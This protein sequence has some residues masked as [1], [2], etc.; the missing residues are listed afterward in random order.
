MAAQGAWIV[1]AVVIARQL[2]HE[3]LA[4]FTILRNTMEMVVLV[5]GVGM[6]LTCI[7][8]I[9]EL[10][11]SDPDGAGRI[12][13]L[14]I[15][16]STLLGAGV[17][18]G[19]VAAASALA[20][21]MH[22]P[23][24]VDLMR[25]TAL[26]IW[27][28][29]Q[30]R[31]LIA[32]QTGIENFRACAWINGLHAGAMLV[33]V[34]VGIIA[35]GITGCLIGLIAATAFA[36]FVGIGMTNRHLRAL[37]I[38]PS[39]RQGWQEW[40]VLRDFSVPSIINDFIS[41]AALWAAMAIVAGAAASYATLGIFGAAW[42]WRMLVTFAP[43]LLNNVLLPMLAA[44]TTPIESARLQTIN[45][46]LQW[47]AVIGIALPMLVAPGLIG[48][49]YG[50]RL[51]SEE[52]N[53]T[54]IWLLA[55]TIMIAYE[56]GIARVMIVRK[57][58]G[59]RL[60]S[61]VFW[62]VVL[63]ILTSVWADHGAE[64]LAMAYTFATAINLVVFL[65]IFLAYQ[66]L[67]RELAIGR[68]VIGIWLGLGAMIAVALECPLEVRIAVAIGLSAGLSFAVRALYRPF[69]RTPNCHR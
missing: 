5:A 45:I 18:F 57:M 37:S 53:R 46:L 23:H 22:A 6:P 34:P 36:V 40:R 65:P 66:L 64:G 2:G 12:I 41:H 20:S 19:V 3:A 32:I 59:W 48:W 27:L 8:F 62:S 58:M 43:R 69:F 39:I 56:T 7:R 47:G 14:G 30:H 16:V 60:A 42:Y 9:A 68:S 49:L 11:R 15:A 50:D 21:A 44:P 33:G 55:A 1:C 28:I 25:L 17:A 51:A 38:R 24:L 35:G 13:G 29:A 26:L 63:L 31:L 10:R 61:N 52:F 67:P 4:D 54:L